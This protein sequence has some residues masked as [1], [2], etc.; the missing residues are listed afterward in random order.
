MA[1]SCEIYKGCNLLGSGTCADGQVNITS[2]TANLGRTCAGRRVQV[3]ITQA[4]THQG[5][6]WGTRVVSEGATTV[7]QDPCPYV[8]A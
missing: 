4:G 5:R 6:H 3:V 7:L 2:Y 1:S 8:G